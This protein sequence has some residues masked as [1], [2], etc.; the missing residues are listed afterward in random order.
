MNHAAK[1]HAVLSQEAC[2]P[3]AR[4]NGWASE[5]STAHHPM[6][7]EFSS[8]HNSNN[9][10]SELKKKS[11]AVIFPQPYQ[12]PKPFMKIAVTACQIGNSRGVGAPF[13]LKPRMTGRRRSM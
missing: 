5:K 4:L 9:A 13:A 3:E 10:H 8:R 11:S 7:T 6:R 1:A 2:P 12:I